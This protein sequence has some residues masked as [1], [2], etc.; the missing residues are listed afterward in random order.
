MQPGQHRCRYFSSQNPRVPHNRT[1]SGIM[2]GDFVPDNV[3]QRYV[4]NE[5]HQPNANTSSAAAPSYSVYTHNVVIN[6]NLT[7]TAQEFT[8]GGLYVSTDDNNPLNKPRGAVR[9]QFPGQSA[10]A[11]KRS[12][13][14]QFSHSKYNREKGGQFRNQNRYHDDHARDLAKVE[15]SHYRSSNDSRYDEQCGS[16]A[17]EN[18]YAK[19][20]NRSNRYNNTYGRYDLNNSNSRKGTSRYKENRS[21]RAGTESRE[22]NWRRA[23]VKEN[24]GSVEHVES[25]N[26]R[27]HNSTQQLNKKCKRMYFIFYLV[28][29]V[30]CSC[31]LKV[32]KL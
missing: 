8:P 4:T 12:G 1:D 22:D 16:A 18:S 30:M 15:N 21:V 27:K 29:S 24:G 32:A 7:P 14:R 3:S 28:T 26:Y 11:S 31:V 10:G 19:G 5:P 25:R 9:K 13:S 23:E 6:S 20:Y 2:N 17:L